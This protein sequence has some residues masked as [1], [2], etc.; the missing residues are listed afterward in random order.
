MAIKV[1]KIARLAAAA[2]LWAVLGLATFW[3]AAALYLDNR[4]GWLRLP[5]AAAYGLGILAAWIFV[6]RPLEAAA[7]AA[8]FAGVLAW[9]FTLQPSNQRN[10]QSGRAHV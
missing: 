7:T 8:G 4:I 9:W 5:L 3:A 2:C 10:W 1:K 6:R